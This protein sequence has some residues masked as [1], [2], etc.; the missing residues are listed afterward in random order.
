MHYLDLSVTDGERR[1][2]LS[3]SLPSSFV[4]SDQVK[5]TFEAGQ[6]SS[7][8]LGCSRVAASRFLAGSAGSAC[9]RRMMAL[10]LD[11]VR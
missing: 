6:K 3:V 2:F 10:S 9:S 11:F 5:G 4:R 1:A 7:K 8:S